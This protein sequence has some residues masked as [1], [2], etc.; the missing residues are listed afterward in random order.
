MGSNLMEVTMNLYISIGLERVEFNLHE[1]D[2][3]QRDVADILGAISDHVR[4]AKNGVTPADLQECLLG[5]TNGKLTV[6]INADY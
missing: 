5:L 6:E 4:D 1:H 2:L 3:T